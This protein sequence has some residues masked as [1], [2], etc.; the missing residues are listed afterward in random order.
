MIRRWLFPVTGVLLTTAALAADPVAPLAPLDFLLGSW[1]ATGG[2][3][4]GHGVGTTTFE[5]QLANKV[6]VR[7]N[8]ADY[9]ATKDRAATT[10]DDLMI[11]YADADGQIRAD[12]YDS[13]GHIIHY[14]AETADGQA[15]FTSDPAPGVGRFRLTYKLSYAGIVSGEFE[16]AP[17]AE[18][19]AFKSY[20]TWTMRHPAGKPK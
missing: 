9:P 10:H 3:T 13:E 19:D 1:E 11:I 12:Y 15:I 20:L 6:V 14:A 17:P 5:R 16:G 18:P 2:G 4:P 8:H 7:R